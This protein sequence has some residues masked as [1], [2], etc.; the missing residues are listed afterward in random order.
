M[1]KRCAGRHKRITRSTASPV[2]EAK[3]VNV[4]QEVSRLT[5]NL[6]IFN[7]DTLDNSAWQNFAVRVVHQRAKTKRFRGFV[8]QAVFDPSR[9]T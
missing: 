3:Y 6:P 2:L 1:A 7:R 8:S 9:R 4:S 5:L